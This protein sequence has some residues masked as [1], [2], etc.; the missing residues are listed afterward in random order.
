M[1]NVLF[2]ISN[3]QTGGVS[4]SMTSLINVIDRERYDVSLM[5]VS[6]SGPL[7]ELLP[8]DLR[9]ITNPVW[10]ALTD[11][12]AGVSKLLRLGHPLLAAGHCIRLLTSCFS[13]SIAGIMIARMMPAINED[14]DVIVDYNGQQQLYYMIDKLK[15]KKKI[16]FFHS[17]Y[18]K[19]PYYYNA[20][21]RYYPK[22]DR[23]FAISD[24]CANSLKRF[25]PE[26][27]DKI[28]LIE[29]I[30]S[31]CLIERMANVKVND[32]DSKSCRLLTIGHVCENK[33]IYWAI[34]A[35]SILKTRGID[36]MWYFIGS[37]DKKD[38]YENLCRKNCVDDRI[39]FLGI[40]TNPYPYIKKAT[41]IV[42][43][44]KFEGRSIA[45][46]EAKL[47]CKP[48]VVTNFSTVKDQFT[49][50]ENA[51]ICEMNPVGIADSI[52]ELLSNTDLQ[53]YYK[54]NLQMTIRDNSDEINKLYKV[55]DE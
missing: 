51:S 33:G 38:E 27:S 10:A 26:Q 12:L 19:W 43:P 11:R 14:F 31:V 13:K 22:V 41:I 3:L 36:F 9:I 17:D 2:I 15:A 5:I 37:V 8:K 30:S 35:A 54:H 45:L 16:T 50:H 28:G 23:I 47:L 21:K 32:M 53:E 20:D 7:M 44:S 39:Q 25:F 48:I 34:E 29:N 24:E 42:H 55:F 4:K 52:E 18:A 49:N 40:R 6:P 1:K 46:D